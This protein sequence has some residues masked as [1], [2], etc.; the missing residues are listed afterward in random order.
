MA[1][2]GLGS[3]WQC[4][5]ANDFDA[6]KAATY[7]SNWGDDAMT[8]ADIGAVS[9]ADVPGVPDLAWAS[10]PCQDLSLAGAGS[11]LAGSRSGTFWM[12]WRLMVEL[13]AEG[14]APKAIVLENV[15]GLLTSSGGRDFT[16]IC[17]ALTVERYRVGAVVV[18]AEP[19]EVAR[20]V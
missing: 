10:F 2:A 6:K 1:R 20:F 4:L 3:G 7:R 13:S 19:L 16:T 17:R 9:V 12:F 11:G 5:F 15:C 18:D 14:R 8:V